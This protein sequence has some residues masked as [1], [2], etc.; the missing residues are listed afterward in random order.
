MFNYQFYFAE[1]WTA[2][3]MCF[4]SVV[5]LVG[6]FWV[7]RRAVIIIRIQTCPCVQQ[8]QNSHWCQQWHVRPLF[9]ED[10]S[11]FQILLWHFCS[12]NNFCTIPSMKQIIYILKKHLYALYVCKSCAHANYCEWSHSC[13]NDYVYKIRILILKSMPWIKQNRRTKYLLFFFFFL[14]QLFQISI[15]YFN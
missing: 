15:I 13:Q 9:K 14:T 4:V 1:F 6:H 7:F 10:S 12:D 2:C 3:Q 11:A 5:S 8:S